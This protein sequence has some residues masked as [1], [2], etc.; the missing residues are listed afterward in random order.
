MS[1][2]QQID[3]NVPISERFAITN[4]EIRAKYA[5]DPSRDPSDIPI[6]QLDPSHPS[7]FESDTVHP[8]FARLRR[9]D[10][11][12]Y[13]NDSMY[14]PFWCVTK[15]RDIVEME[16]A[17][18]TFSSEQRHGGIT[19][20]G[21]PYDTDQPDPTF[22]LPMFIMMDPPKHGEQRSVVQPLFLQRSLQH[23]EPLIRERVVDILDSIPVG[24]EFDWVPTV[25]IDLTARMLATLFDIPQED[26]MKLIHWSDTVQN[27]A[28]PLVYSSMGEAFQELWK[29]HEYF[30]EV[31]ERRKRESEPGNDLISLLAQGE[32]T[33]EMPPN[34]LLGNILLLIVGGNDTTRNSISGGVL[35]LNQYPS[36]YEK[37]QD[38]PSL[39]PNMVSEIVRFQS[40]IAHMAR[41]ALR[42]CEFGG[43]SIRQGD[44]FA[45]WYISGNRDSDAIEGADTFRIDRENARNH[46]A[47]GFGIHRCVGYRLAEMQLRVLWE[48]IES[49][50]ER[51]EVVGDPVYVWSSFLH[52]IKSLPVKVHSK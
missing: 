19:I 2:S 16:K 3:S 21:K 41:T 1:E 50:F 22:N 8:Y 34:E 51:V 18:D 27:A 23:M 49:R 30:G 32:A 20:G 40:P 39:V 37:L 44:R 13:V 12:H 48:E 4:E 26:R 42:D 31:F 6:E 25:A 24:K 11:V 35:F 33:R 5:I 17:Y 45:M 15:Y 14:G 38:N 36:E 43:K 46:L 10:P 9:E 47:F 28:N 52:S 7:L 29:C